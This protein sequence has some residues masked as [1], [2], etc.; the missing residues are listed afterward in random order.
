MWMQGIDE[1]LPSVQLTLFPTWMR[2]WRCGILTAYNARMGT[3]A[4]AEIDNWLHAGGLVVTSSERAARAFQAAFHRRRRSEGLAS[5]PEPNI[6]DWKAFARSAWEERN[7]DGRLL[8]NPAQEQALWSEIIHSEQHLPTALP[9]SVRRLAA[10]AMEAH[11]L[12]AN[13]SPAHLRNGARSGWDGDADAF[14][15]WLTAFDAECLRNNLISLSKVPLELILMLE[16]E[17]TVRSLL[18]AAGFDNLLPT[19]RRLFDTWGQWQQ[20]EVEE[21]SEETYFHHTPDRQTELEACSAWCNREASA[22]PETRLLVVAQD[23]A[24]RRGEIERAFL[25]HGT[26]GSAPRFEFSLGVPLG[27]VQLVRRAFLLLRWLDSPLDENEL[28]WLL[29]NGLA[30]NGTESADLQAYMCALRQRGLQ[31]TRW[32]LEAFINAA[33]ISARPFSDPQVSTTR[34][35]ARLPARWVQRMI[36]AQR[37]LREFGNKPE[38]PIEWAER[39]PQLLDAMGWPGNESSADFQAHRRWQQALDTAGSLGFNGRRIDWREFLSIVERTLNET[40]FAPQ[41]LDA[42]IQI[43]GPAESAGL[44]ADAIWFLGADEDSWPSAASTHPLLHIQVQR[45]AGMPHSTPQRDWDFSL[46]I[47]KRLIASA[48]VVH[49]SFAVQKEDVEARPSRLIAHLAGTPQALPA[50][51]TPPPAEE[52]ATILFSDS[53]HVPFPPG[54]VQGGSSVL[55]FQSQCPFKAFANA[56]LGARDWDPAEFGL[57]AAQRGLL[58]HAVLH[59]IWGEPP[60]AGLRS[61]ADLLNLN[62]REGFVA[63]H[64]RKVLRDEIPAAI[65]DQIPLR[66]LELEELRLVRLVA[67]WLE[68][69]SRRVD[70]TVAETE[71]ER[72]INVAGL[73]LNL[74][75]DRIDRLIDESLLVID[76]KTGDVSS[77]A[78]DLP[79]PDDVQLPLYKIFGLE[80]NGESQS[81]DPANKDMASGGLVF[82]K[83]RT[84]KPC[85]A[86]RVVNARETILNSLN[87]NDSLVR[88]EL[89]AGDEAEWKAK[90]ERLAR[91]F[92]EGR[93]DVDPRDYP[94]TCERCGLQSICRIQE[95]ENRDR[96]ELEDEEDSEGA[97]DE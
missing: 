1:A 36:T 18:R 9:A 90:I 87:G 55:T 38:S 47:T 64:V 42:P 11:E 31:R 79:R 4:G 92:I 21:H 88:A 52:P 65:R 82:A 63:G 24:S 27:Q 96:L 2:P 15:K 29:S 40:L 66:Y 84:G 56:R 58:L 6:L 71:S 62:D 5:W 37:R 57:T 70:F 32:D 19:Q 46:A 61:L 25:C 67:E 49:F 22:N 83:I 41:S 74:R 72:T 69:E 76:Y 97:E 44:T 33:Q 51:M 89:T 93:A 75:L 13:Y 26:A 73:A 39:S 81:V 68:F 86:G 45:D 14:S 3:P 35:S 43:A 12:L 30:S 50:A 77:K 28:D 95:P 20:L 53:S 23:V 34:S 59:R 54:S 80:E 60:P 91:N 17:K 85:F 94:K 48:P 16:E 8:L 78:W 10:M 7:L